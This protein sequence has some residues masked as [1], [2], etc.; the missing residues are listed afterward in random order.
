MDTATVHLVFSDETGPLYRLEKIIP[1]ASDRNLYASFATKDQVID[2]AAQQGF[3]IEV[4]WRAESACQA[5]RRV[6]D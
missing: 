4:R 6:R 2:E 1:A 3:P 5:P